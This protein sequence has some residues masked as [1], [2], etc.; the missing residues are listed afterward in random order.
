MNPLTTGAAIRSPRLIPPSRRISHSPCSSR[1]VR[2]TTVEGRPVSRPP[3]IARS[4]ISR[5][6][7]QRPRRPRSRLAGK[8]G[9]GLEERKAHPGQGPSITLMPGQNCRR[10]RP[11]DSG[12][13]DRDDQVTG[14]GSSLAAASETR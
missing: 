4:T 9:A 5:T 1:S 3:S 14:P 10:G 12:A 6:S 11:A 2:S 8:V 13:G 7:A